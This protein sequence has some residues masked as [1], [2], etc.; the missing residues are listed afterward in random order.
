MYAIIREGNGNY[1]YSMVFGYFDC[2]RTNSDYKHRYW[3]ILNKEKTALLKQ[4]VVDPNSNSIMP[5]V[6]ATDCDDSD[7]TEE[8]NNSNCVNFLPFNDLLNMIDEDRVPKDLL[9]RCIELDKN[10][11][12]NEYPEIHTE[13]D[14]KN[15]DWSVGGF[16]DGRI[17]KLEQSGDSL[18]L[19]FSDLW[20][21]KLE[22]WFEGDVEYDAS[23]RDPYEYDPYWSGGKVIIQDGFIHLIDDEYATV[24]DIAKGWCYF[25]ARKM[26]YHII[27]T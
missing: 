13:R 8:I 23:S 20:G 7:W 15:L 6:L 21:C 1:Y 10:Y 14:I 12:F 17:E 19:L 2:G 26:K 24:E 27:P 5:I 18:Y 9:D 11:Y 25:K 16:H 22:I 3:I 4:A